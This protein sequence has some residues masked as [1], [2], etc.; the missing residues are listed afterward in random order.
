MLLLGKP[1]AVV[2][3][4]HGFVFL[5][6]GPNDRPRLVAKT[7]SAGMAEEAEDE[8]RVGAACWTELLSRPSAVVNCWGCIRASKQIRPCA[9]AAIICFDVLSQTNELISRTA[10]DSKWVSRR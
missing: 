4:R 5:P 3:A 8:T 1:C 6:V 9:V 7:I 2:S 10:S